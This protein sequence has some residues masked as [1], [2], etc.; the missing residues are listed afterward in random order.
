MSQFKSGEKTKK[1]W[2]GDL[3]CNCEFIKDL[4]EGRMLFYDI[5][6]DCFR[7]VYPEWDNREKTY[8][9]NGWKCSKK[10]FNK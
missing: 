5:D 7:L 9:L 2:C 1:I 3:V 8:L 6:N 10:P 4:E